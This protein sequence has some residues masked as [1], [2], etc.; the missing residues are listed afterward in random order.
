MNLDKAHYLVNFCIFGAFG[1]HGTSM[2][3]SAVNDWDRE[4]GH[5]M[6][7]GDVVLLF[8]F[9]TALYVLKGRYEFEKA[10]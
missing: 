5:L 7:W 1:A 2:I 6:P 9:S 10:A 4:W 8:G 3:F